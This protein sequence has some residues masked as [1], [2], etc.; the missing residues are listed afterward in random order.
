[1]RPLFI[2]NDMMRDCLNHGYLKG[3]RF[4]GEGRIPES[5]QLVL[6]EGDI[7]VPYIVEAESVHA[8]KAQ[9]IRGEIYEWDKDL[10]TAIRP[11]MGRTRLV[12]LTVVTEAGPTKC[13][14][15][16]GPS[17]SMDRPIIIEGGDYRRHK[18]ILEASGIQLYRRYSRGTSDPKAQM[19][20]QRGKRRWVQAADKT[21]EQVAMEMDPQVTMDQLKGAVQD[22]LGTSV[23]WSEIEPAAMDLIRMANK[24]MNRD[25]DGSPPPPE[26]SEVISRLMDAMDDP[27]GRT[28]TLVMNRV[29]NPMDEGEPSACPPKPPAE[30]AVE[31]PM[32]IDSEEY[33]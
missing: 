3:A 29:T 30:P 18:A 9:A 22:T 14:A 7:G 32:P 10:L 5:Y 2:A 24:R 25:H 19:S 16:I 11:V 17:Y 20:S 28:L 21:P 15:F 1:M 8:P 33:Q 6:V 27:D 13:S 23:G 31:P 4:L 26:M 12:G